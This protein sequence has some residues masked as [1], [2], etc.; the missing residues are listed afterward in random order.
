MSVISKHLEL[1]KLL[2][3]VLQLLN[4][5]LLQ[6]AR[7]NTA[8]MFVLPF[9]RFV[10]GKVRRAKRWMP[11]ALVAAHPHLAAPTA[12][13]VHSPCEVTLTQRKGSLLLHWWVHR[14]TFKLASA[15][16]GG[17][18]V[19]RHAGLS[20]QTHQYST[21]CTRRDIMFEKF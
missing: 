15:A 7:S 3:V 2:G 19:P 17:T 16:D 8:A 5:V 14:S 11:A 4:H 13:G 10:L 18:A 9:G 6:R 20:A 12:T 21:G 1:C